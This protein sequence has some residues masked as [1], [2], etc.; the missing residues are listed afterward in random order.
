MNSLSFYFLARDN[1]DQRC[2]VVESFVLVGMR[3][4]EVDLLSSNCFIS[5]I[6]DVVEVC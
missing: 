5:S 6:S 4:V 2:V 3:S 1:V